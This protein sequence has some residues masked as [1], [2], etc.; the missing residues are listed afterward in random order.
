MLFLKHMFFVKGDPPQPPEKLGTPN[1][2]EIWVGTE[3]LSDN[4]LYLTLILTQHALEA[5]TISKNN[6]NQTKYGQLMYKR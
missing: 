6:P 3:A 2:N 5:L 1:K 4:W